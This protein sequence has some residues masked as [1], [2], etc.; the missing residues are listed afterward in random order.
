[1]KNLRTA[2]IIVDGKVGV[3][4]KEP[5]L[6]FALYRDATSSYISDT[7]VRE[8]DSCVGY[9]GFVRQHC[10][11][12]GFYPTH[13]VYRPDDHD[14][15][16]KTFLGKTGR[17]NGEDIVEAIVKKPATARFIARHLYNFFVADE[18][19]VPAWNQ[20][21]PLDPQAI[22]ALSAAYFDS[23]GDL[24]A[25]LRV[26]FNA[27]FFKEARFRKVK[28]PAELVASTMKLVGTYRFPDPGLLTLATASNVMG[29]SLLNPPTVEGWHTGKEWID[30]GT[31]NER[32]NAFVDG[33]HRYD[34]DVVPSQAAVGERAEDVVPNGELCRIFA[35][36]AF[37]FDVADGFDRRVFVY[38]QAAAER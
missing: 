10:H 37:A 24:R 13:F 16:V 35:G 5:D 29:Q 14:E 1:M 22:S 19:Q 32:V 18:P 20:M 26:L 12:Y 36:D 23:G 9:I 31:L 28:S 8:R 2:L 30:G 17:F 4:L 11:P 33:R 21:P 38:D 34:F 25:M 7:T 6:T 27:A 15:S 3:R